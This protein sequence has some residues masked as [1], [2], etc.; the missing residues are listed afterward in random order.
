MT[1]GQ[2]ASGWI[3]TKVG[4][5]QFLNGQ[6]MLLKFWAVLNATAWAYHW[7][8]Y[9][10]ILMNPVLSLQAA[11]TAPLIMM[12][13]NCKADHDRIEAH[14][15][16]EINLNAETEIHFSLD[17]PEAQ[18]VAIAEIHKMLEEMRAEKL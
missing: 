7:D 18:N 9:P 2:R 3:A 12:N 6:S 17:N 8:P 15:D 5:R 13:Q 16:Y 10:F 11:Y 14:V 4:S 1:L